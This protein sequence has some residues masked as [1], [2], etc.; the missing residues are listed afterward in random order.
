MQMQVLV[1][2]TVTLRCLVMS[3]L[4]HL[5][6]IFVLHVRQVGSQI[7]RQTVSFGISTWYFSGSHMVHV[8]E[9]PEHDKQLGSH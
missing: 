5:V 7:N 2:V 6:T 4:K 3:Q 8:V 9:F 1:L